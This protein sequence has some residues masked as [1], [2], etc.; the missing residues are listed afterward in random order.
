ML[1]EVEGLNTADTRAVSRV[2]AGRVVAGA[3]ELRRDLF[4][5]VGAALRASPSYGGGAIAW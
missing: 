2:D 4:D 5:R 3:S 1:R